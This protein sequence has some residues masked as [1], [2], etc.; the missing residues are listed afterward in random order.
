MV[1]NAAPP[2]DGGGGVTEGG[3]GDTGD[4]T[5]ISYSD[6]LKTNVRF[7]QR[8][9]RNVLEITLEKDDKNG[10]FDVGGEDVARVARTLGIDILSQTQG[11]QIKY[12]G[13]FSV[14]SV[15]MVPGIDLDRFCK[16][17]NIKVTDNVT[18]GVIRP[19]GKKDVT[20]SIVGLDFNTPDNFVFEY[21]SKFGVLMNQSVIYSKIESGAWKGKYSGERKY[22]VDFTKA[23]LS[24]GTYHL[25]DGCKVRVYYRGN[26]K[27]CGRCQKTAG[28]CPGNGIARE[29]GDNGGDRVMLSEHMKAL[30]SRVGFV[31]IAFELHSDGNVEDD[32]EQ[33]SM[34]RDTKFQPT[35]DRPKPTS[36]D[37]EFSNGV[38]LRNIPIAIEE[39]EILPFLGN[40]GVPHDHPQGNIKINRRDKNTSVTIEGISPTQVETIVKAIHFPESQTKFFGNPVYCKPLRSMTPEKPSLIQN[41]EKVEASKEHN[42]EEKKESE[43]K[44]AKVPGLSKSA[45]KKALKKANDKKAREDKKKVEAAKNNPKS[46]QENKAS[47]EPNV[48]FDFLKKDLVKCNL[49]RED[50]EDQFNFDDGNDDDVPALKIHTNSKFF[51]KEST[52]EEALEEQSQNLNK[53]HLSPGSQEKLRKTKLK[54]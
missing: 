10:E 24:M 13:N 52:N 41:D 46:H 27:T 39:T 22:Q 33:V 25:I 6:R 32:G 29:C 31:P 16:D 2:G 30:W 8:L 35:I 48:R 45:E 54:L 15:W 47:K 42:I 20:V 9:K 43:N 53:R 18:T 23:T 5:R 40:H 7:D 38:I 37:I 34:I 36:R 19:S 14:F 28:D 44:S 51:R 21:L 17:V 11:Y 49:A 1:E 4:K 50:I 12:M 3:S 26:K